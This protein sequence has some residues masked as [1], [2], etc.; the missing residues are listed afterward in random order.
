MQSPYVQLHSSARWLHENMPFGSSQLST[1]W[2]WVCL[3][4][5]KSFTLCPDPHTLVLGLICLP[6]TM[7]YLPTPCILSDAVSAG[8]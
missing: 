7:S 6:V 3:P 1:R 8:V 4:V 2:C 5:G